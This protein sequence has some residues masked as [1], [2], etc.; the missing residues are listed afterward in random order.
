MNYVVLWFLPGLIALGLITSYEDLKKSRIR[1][2]YLLAGLIFSLVVNTYLFITGQF[3]IQYVFKLIMYSSIALALGFI[4]WYTGVWS[5]G[6]AKLFACYTVMIPI[7]VYGSNPSDA[8]ITA[9][10]I[11]TI[12]PVF[13]VLVTSSLIKTSKK[14]KIDTLK[15]TLNWKY[16]LSVLLTVFGLGFILNYIFSTIWPTNSYALRLACILILAS[17]LGFVLKENMLP[18]MALLSL[19]RV[20]LGK[21][22]IFSK[23]FIAGFVLLTTGYALARIII[24]DLGKLFTTKVR[25]QDLKTGMI[26]AE[27]ITKKGH[28]VKLD[29]IWNLRKTGK[30]DFFYIPTPDG[31]KEKEIWEI[32]RAH[33]NGRLHFD[34]LSIQQKMPF[35]PFMFLGAILTVIMR[36]N[37]ISFAKMLI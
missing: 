25:I 1:N 30:K 31:L 15:K 21:E 17:V 24:W 28:S 20:F 9:P 27:H 6:D 29:K 35:A 23:S 33:Y 26:P 14:Q 32:Q 7:A 12:V 8:P 34:F 37:F 16:I 4:F 5:A 3:G 13:L 2:K 11:N 10:L 36:T 19:L 18:F 22:Y